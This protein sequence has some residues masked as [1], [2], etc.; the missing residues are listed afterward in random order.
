V[1]HVFRAILL[2]ANLL[3]FPVLLL[4][5]C[6]V[7]CNVAGLFR[8]QRRGIRSSIKHLNILS[9]LLF[10]FFLSYQINSI[11]WG[12]LAGCAAPPVE[13]EKSTAAVESM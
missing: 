9:T 1:L 8:Q 5:S 10:F 11:T 13:R 4:F 3:G 2:G 7:S 6:F 12:W